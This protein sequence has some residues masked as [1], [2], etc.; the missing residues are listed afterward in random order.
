MIGSWIRSVACDNGW[1][2]SHTYLGGQ[3]GCIA[4]KLLPEQKNSLELCLGQVSAKI[5]MD[6][7]KWLEDEN[8]G[9]HTLTLEF[10]SLVLV[11]HEHGKTWFRNPKKDLKLSE[12]GLSSAKCKPTSLSGNLT[13]DQMSRGNVARGF[14]NT[15]LSRIPAWFRV[16][17]FI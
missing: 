14:L 4:I 12:I 16:V 10:G 6:F 3:C 8:S 1:I 5:S 9:S 11:R 7:T 17:S 15:F 2:S 13:T